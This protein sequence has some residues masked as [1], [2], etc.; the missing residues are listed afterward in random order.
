[1]A[2]STGFCFGAQ[3]A[4]RGGN[5]ANVHFAGALFTNAFQFAF[6]KNSLS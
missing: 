2:E 3:V 6:L 1:L 5:D 4:I